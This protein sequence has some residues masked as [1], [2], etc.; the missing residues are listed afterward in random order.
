MNALH[1]LTNIDLATLPGTVQSLVKVMGFAP[2]LK[3]VE[4]YGGTSLLVSQ[5]ISAAGQRSYEALAEVV[6]YEACRSL[7]NSYPGSPVIYIPRCAKLMRDVRD[8][9][10]RSE[11]D[12]YI[13]DES[14]QRAIAKL[15]R[16]YNLCDRQIK[17][18]LK[19]PDVRPVSLIQTSLF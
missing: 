18:I 19:K 8:N 17:N 16:A 5:G 12:A 1:T 14:G 3:L 9:Q 10:I 15:A 11:Y 2:A 13:A 6:G 7:A 4:Q